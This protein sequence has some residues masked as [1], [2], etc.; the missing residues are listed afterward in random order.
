MKKTENIL[1]ALTA[2]AMQDGQVAHMRTV[3]QKELLHYD[4]LYCL[5][6]AGLLGGLVFQ[7]GTSLRLCYGADRYSEDLD[8]AGGPDFSMARFAALKHRVESHVGGR[9]GLEV[10][11]REP[12]SSPN[13]PARSGVS[14]DRWRVSVV[15]H[16]ER[17]DIPKQR[18][19]I[20]IASVPAYT[21]EVRKLQANYEFLPD[22]YADLLVVVESLDEIMADKLLAL[23]ASQKHVRHRDFWDLAWLRQR[24][25]NVQPELVERKISDYEVADYPV[26]LD[27][28]IE[29]APTIISG[30]EFQG[31]MK[32]FLPDDRYQRSFGN[33]N[34]ELYLTATIGELFGELKAGLA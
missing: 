25:A 27:S 26:L 14:V 9:Y 4:I 22:G 11:V 6:H 10:T 32:R 1:D 2:R 19:H 15:T 3:I 18:V 34:F 30:K 24:G 29:R 8:F 23:P 17:K 12:K 28:L 20:E 13:E 5:E 33:P 16:P 31:Q 7:G 21:S